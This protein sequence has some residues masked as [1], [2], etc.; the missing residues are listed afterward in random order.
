MQN[1][2]HLRK[3]EL[4]LTSTLHKSSSMMLEHSSQAL[5]IDQAPSDNSV[6]EMTE[7]SIRDFAA[8]FGITPRAVRFYEDKG[9][10]K[11]ARKG[12][13]RIFTRVDYLRLEKILR[14]KRL[15]F[16]LDDIKIVLDVT[17]GL[18]SDREAL[19]AHRGMF[20]GVIRSLQRRRED[21]D[22]V[23]HD[24][25]EICRVITETL[26]ATPPGQDLS[27]MAA[28]YEAV[29]LTAELPPTGH[30]HTSSQSKETQHA[31]L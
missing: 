21:I 26:V 10:L 5:D 4:T 15:G 16:S 31:E 30:T 1:N 7:A 18:V 17:D 29:F 14:A 8:F 2:N 9:L 20:E 27:D 23:A 6:H 19:N 11:P 13:T 22:I 3:C 25:T 24:M 12:T 28:Q